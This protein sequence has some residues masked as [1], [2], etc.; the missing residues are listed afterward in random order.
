MVFKWVV[1][2]YFAFEWAIFGYHKTI[3]TV[4]WILKTIK[5]Q[6]WDCVKMNW[7]L[8]HE[9]I[10]GRTKNDP[11]LSKIGSFLL[12]NRNC[13]NYTTFTFSNS[14]FNLNANF[15]FWYQ[16]VMVVSVTLIL[17]TAVGDQMCWWQ[18]WDV[19]DRFNTLRKS[20]T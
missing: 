3:L 11:L 14:D 9:T 1:G 17:V 13:I 15:L 8:D 6:Y 12:R 19:G 5:V 4:L 16:S 2:T 7:F 10:Y 18:V 20:P